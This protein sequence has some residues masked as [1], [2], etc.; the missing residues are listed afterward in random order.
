MTSVTR[1]FQFA[2]GLR[3]P[4]FGDVQRCLLEVTKLPKVDEAYNFKK[5]RN[6]RVLVELPGFDLRPKMG[7]RTDLNVHQSN[8]MPNCASIEFRRVNNGGGLL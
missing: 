3:S 7:A 2:A 1:H 4:K 5:L 8:S 6:L